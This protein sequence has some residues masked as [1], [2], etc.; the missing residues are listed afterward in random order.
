MLGSH[1][2]MTEEIVQK[3]KVIVQSIMY[4]ENLGKSYASITVRLYENLQAILGMSFP[5]DPD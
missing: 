5:P 1:V 4:N 3:A 2:T